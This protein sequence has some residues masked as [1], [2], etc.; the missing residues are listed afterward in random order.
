MIREKIFTDV[1]EGRMTQEN[2][3][4]MCKAVHLPDWDK[5]CYQVLIQMIHMSMDINSFGGFT[6]LCYKEYRG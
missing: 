2:Y 3:R 5:K 1:F 6:A 4:T